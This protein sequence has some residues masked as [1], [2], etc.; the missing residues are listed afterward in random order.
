MRN[1]LNLILSFM[2]VLSLGGPS[3]GFQG[4]CLA[5]F[6][7]PGFECYW[8]SLNPDVMYTAFHWTQFDD[9]LRQT[10]AKAAGRP[11][12]ID[13]E[14]HGDKGLVLA[15]EDYR[16]RT[17]IYDAAGLGFVVNHIEK[18]L[19][20]QDVTLLTEA[21]FAGE[22][23]RE[24]IRHNRD[25]AENHEGVPTF[26]IYGASYNYMNVNNLVYLQYVTK[27]RVWFEDLRVYESK[28]GPARVE[29]DSDP[30]YTKMGKL[31]HLLATLFVPD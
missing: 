3:F 18:E 4:P 10:K 13:L 27:C 22:V 14:C 12:V 19:A 20:G 11:I 24:T 31:Y 23:Y 25:K 5:V 17:K 30:A 8:P 21:C 1:L 26:P 9:F 28:K 6:C 16:T 7:N 15:Y 2:L 29:D